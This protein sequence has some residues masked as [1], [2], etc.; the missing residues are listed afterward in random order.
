MLMQL[1]SLFLALSISP[2]HGD[3][4]VQSQARRAAQGAYL[5]QV[6]RRIR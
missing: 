1:R 2:A 4:R 6:T 5:V 3:R